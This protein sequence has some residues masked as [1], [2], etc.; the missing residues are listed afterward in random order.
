MMPSPRRASSISTASLTVK[1]PYFVAFWKDIKG[2]VI[3]LEHRAV[4][5]LVRPASFQSEI[6]ISPG[7]SGRGPCSY[8]YHKRYLVRA[9]NNGN[10]GWPF[11]FHVGLV[12]KEE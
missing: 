1:L 6:L 12:F 8:L 9:I 10:D 7:N 3:V 5:G 2:T 4:D 11:F